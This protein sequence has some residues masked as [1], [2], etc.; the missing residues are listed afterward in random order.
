MSPSASCELRLV[1][2]TLAPLAAGMPS[3][4]LGVLVAL[5]AALPALPALGAAALAAAAALRWEGVLEGTLPA[6]AAGP[7]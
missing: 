6:A 3:S 4:P 1:E 2:G 5:L 7:A